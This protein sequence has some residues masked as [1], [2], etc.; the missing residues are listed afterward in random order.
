M[1]KIFLI[2]LII[3]PFLNAQQYDK[4]YINLVFNGVSI[5]LPINAV[6]INKENAISI[7]I[8]AE[9]NDSEIQK[10]VTLE[11][12][13]RELSIKKDA[14]LL[15]GITIDVSTSDNTTNSGSS[16]YI[17]LGSDKNQE[18]AHYEK[19]TKGKKSNWKINSISLK[20]NITDIKYFNGTLHLTGECNGMFK[21]NDA[22]EN[23]A[24]EIKNGKFEIII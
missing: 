3:I 15:D 16:L 6:S 12:K 9:Q 2:V 20:V 19:L 17:R 21:S 10:R 4:G 13:L 18:A 1:K 23:Q 11:L 5:D 7:R 8:S 14:E 24:A 22:P